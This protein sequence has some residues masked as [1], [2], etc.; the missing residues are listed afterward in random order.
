MADMVKIP[1]R[2][3]SGI[4]DFLPCSLDLGLVGVFQGQQVTD[5]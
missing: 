4:P 2:T 5:R 3:V 1:Q